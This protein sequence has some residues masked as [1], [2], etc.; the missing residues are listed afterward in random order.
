MFDSRPCLLFT[1]SNAAF[2]NDS[3]MQKLLL[4]IYI[5]L[6]ISVI[7]SMCRGYMRHTVC[8]CP[9]LLLCYALQ[10]LHCEAQEHD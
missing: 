3:H 6:I 9:D 1:W 5:I 7:Q 10:E 8:R 2:V 4:Q